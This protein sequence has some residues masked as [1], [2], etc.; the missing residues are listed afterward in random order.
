MKYGARGK[1]VDKDAVDIFSFYA[2]SQYNVELIDDGIN[3]P[4]PRFIWNGR[5]ASIS[6]MRSMVNDILATC[7]SAM[8]EEENGLITVYQDRPTQPSALFIRGNVVDGQMTFT[9]APLDS[10]VTAC[11]VTFNDRTNRFEPSTLLAKS[12]DSLLA[13]FGYRQTN[14]SLNGVV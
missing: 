12:E 6:N 5:I 9:S 4:H 10:R 2:A 14:I 7:M 3:P 13:S 8:Y 1:T 11:E